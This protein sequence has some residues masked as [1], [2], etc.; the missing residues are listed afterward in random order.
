MDKRSSRSTDANLVA[1]LREWAGVLALF[2]V[3]TGGVAYAANTVFSSD[4]VNGEVK[5]VD[6]GDNQVQ[7]VDVKDRSLN[8]ADRGVRVRS[9]RQV[10]DGS[11]GAVC[12]QGPDFDECVTVFFNLPRPQRLLLVGSGEWQGG[13]GI[14]A[15]ECSFAVGNV[16]DLGLRKFSGDGD[17]ASGSN[18]AM[19]SV[20]G[21]LAQG[22]YEIAIDCR[23]TFG[24]MTV[25][26]TELSVAAL[27]DG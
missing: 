4:I 24:S 9:E 2:L 23:E 22:A 26:N 21:V 25:T 1:S 7:G 15:G 19:N 18:I 14:N 10:D 27:G 5:S 16:A 11:G 8:G 13:S 20:T 12:G 3:L 17:T 6:I